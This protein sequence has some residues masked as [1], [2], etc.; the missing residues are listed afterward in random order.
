MMDKSTCQENSALYNFKKRLHRLLPQITFGVFV[1]M[2]VGLILGKIALDKQVESQRKTSQ[3][4]DN[5]S[6]EIAALQQHLDEQVATNEA[7][8]QLLVQHEEN[9]GD[10][11]DYLVKHLEKNEASNVSKKDTVQ[12]RNQPLPFSYFNGAEWRV[13]KKFL[14]SSIGKVTNDVTYHNGGGG[15]KAYKERMPGYVFI[16]GFFIE[17]FEILDSFNGEMNDIYVMAPG[18]S[19]VHKN[20][21]KIV[22]DKDEDKVILDGCL[23]WKKIDASENVK[24]DLWIATDSR[25]YERKVQMTKDVNV[26]IEEQCDTKYLEKSKRYF[27]KSIGRVKNL[28]ALAAVS[29]EKTAPLKLAE[30]PYDKS[31]S[32]TNLLK[33]EAWAKDIQSK[34]E[35]PDIDFMID[36]MKRGVIPTE[37][38]R[39]RNTDYKFYLEPLYFNPE[40]TVLYNNPRNS[41]H[42]ND[43]KF[44]ENES[45][46][47]WSGI[48]AVTLTNSSEDSRITCSDG[49]QLYFLGS[50]E[51]H[52]IDRRGSDVISIGRGGGSIQAGEG[53]DLVLIEKDWGNIKVSKS[54]HSSEFKGGK[55]YMKTSF[56]EEFGG[57]G[58]N[59]SYK[60]NNLFI[61]SVVPGKPAYSAS[62]VKGDRIY[63]IDGQS[64]STMNQVD[65]INA[66][67]GDAG[68]PVNI[69]YRSYK[70]DEI[71]TVSLTRELMSVSGGSYTYAQLTNFEWPYKFINFIIFGP[72]IHPENMVWLSENTILAEKHTNN[73]LT[74]PKCFNLVFSESGSIPPVDDKELPAPSE[75]NVEKSIYKAKPYSSYDEIPGLF[76]YRLRTGTTFSEYIKGVESEFLKVNDGRPSFSKQS[77]QEQQTRDLNKKKNKQILEALKY[78][79]NIDGV[80][81]EEEATNYFIENNKNL[82]A[83][84]RAQA[85]EKVMRNDMD[86][87]KI[88]TREEMG[89]LPARYYELNKGSADNK[90]AVYLAIDPNNDG[91]LT[92]EEVKELA[93]KSFATVDYDEN[94]L[95]SDKEFKASKAQRRK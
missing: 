79:L 14:K 6:Q 94:H 19:N 46:G 74:I 27:L 48:Q 49:D 52:I 83:T 23:G 69:K 65:T 3:V 4:L 12:G 2:I 85:V 72:G 73:I 61:N 87:N 84:Y 71:N 33:Y 10:L 66:L 90:V 86:R 50:G 95:L 47:V 77:Y 67:R 53:Q 21:I 38:P 25:G 60:D 68:T 8:K 91:I 42:N 13:H 54:C 80:V 26:S 39:Y 32:Q 37:F 63:E 76:I 9:V 34:Q 15:H 62:L 36:L 20:A 43:N 44:C 75:R 16:D 88:L 35:K 58:I 81:T 59:S 5:N 45:W 70:T 64:V 29:K 92:L 31:F 41:R 93:E 28:N 56:T 82:N 1:V 24:E 51:D 55:I 22:S 17:N 57:I 89:A 18:I 40:N 30:I 78:D 7:Q 11:E